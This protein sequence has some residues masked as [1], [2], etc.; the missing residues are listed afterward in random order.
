[1]LEVTLE[2]ITT[3]VIDNLLHETIV[4]AIK[5]GMSIKCIF[6]SLLDQ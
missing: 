3:D 1:M 2:D 6:F 5:I 4:T